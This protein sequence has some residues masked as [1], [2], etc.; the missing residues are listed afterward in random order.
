MFPVHHNLRSAEKACASLSG[1]RVSLRLRCTVTQNARH[2]PRYVISLLL[3]AC[4][5]VLSL[6]SRAHADDKRLA[7]D[8]NAPPTRY[9]STGQF[10][11]PFEIAPANEPRLKAVL[12]LQDRE[13]GGW[14]IWKKETAAKKMFSLTGVKDGEYRLGV[15]SFYDDEP[16][17]IERIDIPTAPELI[18]VVDSRAPVL[19]LSMVQTGWSD[20]QIECVI[21]E[22]YPDPSSIRV[23]SV[24]TGPGKS[25]QQLAAKIT[26]LKKEGRQ[27]L[28]RIQCPMRSS[29]SR[30]RVELRDRSGNLGR[31]DLNVSGIRKPS[32]V[33]RAAAVD[34]KNTHDSE[35][36]ADIESDSDRAEVLDASAKN[37]RR[38]IPKSSS[39]LFTDRDMSAIGWKT[40]ESHSK[41]K[42][43][44]K[45]PVIRLLSGTQSDEG[46]QDEF[47]APQFALPPYE[48]AGTPGGPAP[49]EL[50]PEM[51]PPELVS[52]DES[53]SLNALE[54]I[55][56]VVPEIPE[57]PSG[58]DVTDSLQSSEESGDS[59]AVADY[60]ILL[61]SARNSVALGEIEQALTRF[62][63]CIKLDPSRLD[64]RREYA[65]LLAS[66]EQSA[67]IPVLESVLNSDPADSKTAAILADMLLRSGRVE[68]AE[69]ILKNATALISSDPEL[70]RLMVQVLVARGR[71]REAGVYFDEHMSATNTFEPAAR[72]Q[73]ISTLMLLGRLSDALPLAEAAANEVPGDLA[74]T[75][76]LISLL[77]QL[78]QFEAAAGAA[79]ALNLDDPDSCLEAITLVR[80]LSEQGQ[81]STAQM[82]L[83]RTFEVDPLHPDALLAEADL[84]LR[85]G[86]TEGAR[87]SLERG[88]FPP[89]DPRV[90]ELRARIHLAAGEF[91]QARVITGT[92]L[93]RSGEIPIIL[94]Q[95]RLYEAM[96]AF[97]LAEQIYQSAL[98]THPDHTEI[99]N[100]LAGLYLQTGHEE[101]ALA[102]LEHSLQQ[103][104]RDPLTWRLWVQA[105]MRHGDSTSA[106]ARVLTELQS[107]ECSPSFSQHLHRL[108]GC[109]YFHQNNV[110]AASTEFQF[111]GIE[112]NPPVDDPESAY[113]FYMCLVANGDSLRADAFL[114]SCLTTPAF[115]TR[116]VAIAEKN[117]QYP[118]AKRFVLELSERYPGN[119]T[120]L[121]QFSSLMSRLGD[122]SAQSAFQALLQRAP[123]SVPARHGMALLHWRNENFEQALQFYDAVLNDV[124]E[125]RDAARD[126]ARLLRQSQGREAAIAG[127]T[128]AE[129][130]L[131][132]PILS[133]VHRSLLDDPNLIRSNIGFNSLSTEQLFAL[134]LER[135]ATFLADWRPDN[136]T[137]ALRRLQVLNPDDSHVAFLLAQQNISMGRYAEAADALEKLLARD[138]L[139]AQ[140]ALA[141]ERTRQLLRPRL[142]SHFST[143]SQSGR[144]GLSEISRTRFGARYFKP[145]GTGNDLFSIGYSHIMLRPSGADHVLGNSLDLGYLWNVS[146]D[147]RINAQMNVEQYNEG[148]STKPV[149]RIDAKHRVLDGLELGFVSHLENV[150]ENS[151]SIAQEIFR[152]G[153]GPTLDWHLSQRWE[154]MADYDI[155]NYSDSNLVQ[156]FNVRNI[157]KFTTAPRELR[158]IL[159]YHFED[160]SDQTV[161]N[162]VPDFLP[163][164][165]HPYFAP[166][167]FSYVNAGLE[168]QHW[169]NPMTLGE[170]EFSYTVRY[171]LQWDTLQVFYNTFGAA[172]NWDFSETMRL[173]VSTDHILSGEYDS[174]G[175]MATLMISLPGAR[176]FAPV[177]RK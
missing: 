2:C 114:S 72:R 50:G 26:S 137:A 55:R 53:P 158:G 108:A 49:D 148:F 47:V 97:D 93:S 84:L 11:I 23:L 20:P 159:H 45:A 31:E 30:I 152:Y 171:A 40:Q 96:T 85:Q 169:L 162:P 9:V 103:Q 33:A 13:T 78:G 56:P 18:V 15:R 173:S 115:G 113:A 105:A 70:N 51:G 140:A 14:N 36:E 37:D 143:F 12:L 134:R 128:A 119:Q 164:T 139:H 24:P 81:Y 116:L 161:R 17:A 117:Q 61:R 156:T 74:T 157:Y 163:G 111:S 135:E 177:R 10:S 123:L 141:L 98:A 130:A 153:I 174:S 28:C 147:F 3:A 80:T 82:L 54:P 95:G 64:A 132:N 46:E 127:Y 60:D 62:R 1:T 176:D 5:S 167:L 52:N 136:T 86:F 58:T 94:L 43:K 73:V 126:R 29:V 109:L 166:D 91:S 124:P 71:A 133:D 138:P 144:N 7:A 39:S 104:S 69:T 21:A 101:K 38:S 35:F 92:L 63:E 125:H 131:N 165:I 16:E 170:Y 154:L 100:A 41:L 25:P 121:E 149:F 32:T 145:I 175:V 76:D 99:R 27:W 87:S 79:S 120:V 83:K 48:D 107:P 59:T 88:R 168:W 155:Q 34:E 65:H 77:V 68:K 6:T 118:L 75:K 22:Q 172:L 66:R 106:M 19:V 102:V 142:G 42:S 57:M 89:E 151:E 90:L 67:A 160:F 129:N 112:V 122:P 150:A 110:A 44:R 146:P 8:S 4:M